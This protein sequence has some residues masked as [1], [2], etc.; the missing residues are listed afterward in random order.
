MDHL[1]TLLERLGAPGATRNAELAVRARQDEDRLVDAL[2]ERF[3]E[4][5]A[6][7]A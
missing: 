1:R 5:V 2:L 3:G 7:V 4:A 6:R